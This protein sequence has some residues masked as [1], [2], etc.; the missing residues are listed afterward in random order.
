MNYYFNTLPHLIETAMNEKEVPSF[1]EEKINAK[2]AVTDNNMRPI[3]DIMYEY[4]EHYD[5]EHDVIRSIN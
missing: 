3:N 1:S 4:D 2:E 5:N